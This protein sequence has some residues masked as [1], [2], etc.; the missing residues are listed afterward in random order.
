MFITQWCNS[1]VCNTAPASIKV[2]ATVAAAPEYTS[3]DHVDSAA[4]VA[5]VTVAT[6][7]ATPKQEKPPIWL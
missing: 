5:A 3:T 1:Y 2:A 4:A 6:E 7:N